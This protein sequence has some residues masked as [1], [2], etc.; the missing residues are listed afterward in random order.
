M[1]QRGADVRP[2]RSTD[3][4][5]L[6]GRAPQ[7]VELHVP[8]LER[9]F[10]E[11]AV[12]G[13]LGVV[14]VRDEAVTSGALAAARV[15]GIPGH[16]ALSPVQYRGGSGAAL[17]A[18][19]CVEKFFGCGKEVSRNGLYVEVENQVRY[20]TQSDGVQVDDAAAQ[21]E[22]RKFVRLCEGR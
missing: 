17:R 2:T 14:R 15:R 21:R 8:A 7:S 20:P 11:A 16:V 10:S 1:E 6:L 22:M 13:H 4:D 9:F 18:A 3:E 19:G 5:A 12:Q